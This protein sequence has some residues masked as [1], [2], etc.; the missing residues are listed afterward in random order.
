VKVL[1]IKMSSL[2]DVVHTLPA[3]TDAAQQDVTLDWVVEEAFQS[4]PARHAGVRN[5]IP[6]A[7]RRWRGNLLAHRAALGEFF[8]RLRRERYDLVIDAQGLLKSAAVVMLAKTRVVAGYSFSSARE[9]GAA[10]FYDQRITVPVGGHAIDRLRAL[11]A[12]AL[13][14]QIPQGPPAFGL[15]SRASE[16]KIDRCLLLHGTTWASKHWPLQ[17]WQAQSARLV[18]A[19]WQVEVPWGD[20]TERT[21]AME[22]A[23]GSDGVRVLDAMNLDAMIDHIAGMG[24]VIGVDSGLTH[25]AGA[26]A[27]PTLVLYGA[28]SAV[29]T[30]VRGRRVV[31]LQSDLACSPC[32]RR[33]CRYQGEQLNWQGEAVSPACYA[34][35][36]PERVSEEVVRLLEDPA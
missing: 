16:P 30:G 34:G 33:Q 26:L 21:R 4:I 35:L 20:E 36:S 17:M 6:I 29:R 9:P 24:L 12:N 8:A 28:T 18:T 2:G 22:V 3:V 15:S 27:V 5:V 14:Y 19:G 1:L 10:L 32:L 13:G 31:N 23:A 25:L 7:W 11:F